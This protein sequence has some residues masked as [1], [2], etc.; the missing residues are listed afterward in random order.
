[1]QTKGRDSRRWLCEIKVE[2]AGARLQLVY[3]KLVFHVAAAVAP[4]PEPGIALQCVRGS[5]CKR[6]ACTHS[7]FC[8][9]FCMQKFP[10]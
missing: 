2:R 5:S 3:F 1:M 10:L 9:A 6:A 4:G 8:T 7:Y